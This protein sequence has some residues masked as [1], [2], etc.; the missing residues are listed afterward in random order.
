MCPS[1]FCARCQYE[2]ITG[3]QAALEG[4]GRDQDDGILSWVAL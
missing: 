2:N 4:L 3:K 1:L